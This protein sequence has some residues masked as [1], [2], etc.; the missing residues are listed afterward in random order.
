MPNFPARKFIESVM[1]IHFLPYS[2]F[3]SSTKIRK[4]V[5]NASMFGPHAVND[6]SHD[7]AMFY[8]NEPYDLPKTNDAALPLVIYDKNSRRGVVLTPNKW[9]IYTHF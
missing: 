2:E 4:E 8:W 7:H 3:I 5:Y 6:E 9:H 1:P